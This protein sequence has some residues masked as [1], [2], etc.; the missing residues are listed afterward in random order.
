MHCGNGRMSFILTMNVRSTN[1]A[2]MPLTNFVLLFAVRM[3]F[4]WDGA[5]FC[6]PLRPQSCRN[7]RHISVIHKVSYK[8]QHGAEMAVV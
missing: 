8:I 5:P 6:W 3:P 7:C 1:V 4:Y 2:F